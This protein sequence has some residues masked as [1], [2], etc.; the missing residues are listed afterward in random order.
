MRFF[1]EEQIE[2]IRKGFYSAVYFNRT[3]EVLRASQNLQIATMQIFQK[4]DNALLCG[5]EEVTELLQNATG[6]FE[7]GAWIDK[8]SSLNIERLSEGTLLTKLESV[9]HITGPYAY[10]AHL[11]SL[12]L[13]ILARRTMVATNVHDCVDAAKGKSVIFFADRFDNFLNQ[14]GDGYAAKRGGI[15]AVCTEAMTSW[16]GGQAVGTVPHA[17]IAMEQGDTVVAA[18]KFADAFSEVPVIALADF[19]NDVVKTSLALAKALGNT[20]YGVRL[21]TSENLV[22]VSL[23]GTDLTG[24]NPQL[25]KLVRKALD[26]AGYP[27][28]KMVVSG[29]FNAE[30][31]HLFEK[32][33]A[34][35]DIYGVGSSLLK[36][37]FDFT[38]DIV[39]VGDKNIAKFGR[40]YTPLRK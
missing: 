24:V 19:H 35:V 38:A 9:M 36:G 10:F 33:N 20:L 4:N 15:S 6:Y 40:Q 14:E 29:G 28:V 27:Q 7:N 8:S 32:E 39:R 25:V 17:L 18:Q 12:Y 2:K 26:Q 23:Q 30:K 31:I 13:G 21:D 22:D 34:P 1:T 37:T 5:V 16:I 11:E 3:K